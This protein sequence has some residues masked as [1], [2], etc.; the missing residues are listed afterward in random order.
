MNNNIH[1][2]LLYIIIIPSWNVSQ[3]CSRNVMRNCVLCKLKS[4]QNRLWLHLLINYGFRFRHLYRIYTRWHH[5]PSYPGRTW[6]RE[7]RS[8]WLCASHFPINTCTVHSTAWSGTLWSWCVATH[9]NALLQM[10][11]NLG[12]GIKSLLGREPHRFSTPNHKVVG[13]KNC[14]SS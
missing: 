4:V 1:C 6:K 2:T 12:M 3:D 11:Y 8:Q 14:K 9:S 7:D 13:G 5:I 10:P